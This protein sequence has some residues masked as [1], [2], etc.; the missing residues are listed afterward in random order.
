MIFFYRLLSRVHKF[1]VKRRPVPFNFRSN[2][3]G[4]SI[5]LTEPYPRFFRLGDKTNWVLRSSRSQ[6]IEF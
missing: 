4:Q 6:I 5:V 2:Y 3:F 1:Y